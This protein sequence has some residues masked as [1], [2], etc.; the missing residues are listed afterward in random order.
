MEQSKKKLLFDYYDN[1]N[2]ITEIITQL[3][4]HYEVIVCKWANGSDNLRTK[5]L[6]WADIIFCEWGALNAIWYSMNKLPHQQ[7]YIRLHRWE[8]YSVFFQKIVWKNVT[9]TIFISPQIQRLAIL[10]NK[11][12]S[13]K[14]ICIYN[15]VKSVMF[16]DTDKTIDSPFNIGIM[17]ILPHYKRLDIAIDIIQYLNN[18]DNKYKLYILG[19]TY[20]DKNV[21]MSWKSKSERDFYESINKKIKLLHLENIVIFEPYTFQPEDWLKKIGFIL[22]LSDIEGSH[23]A[24][25][26]SMATGAIPCIYGKALH[27][28]KLDEIYPKKYCFYESNI[29]VLCDK[30]ISYSNNSDSLVNEMEYCKQFCR[31]NFTLDMIYKQI[32]DI[33]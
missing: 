5:Y 15:Y 20:K 16:S 28:F 3:Q 25:A 32:H 17:G 12:I 24:V 31:D 33:L 26:E 23:Q 6:K 14:S 10:Q 29:N 18:K 19:K 8:L 7:L 11:E 1:N 2:F 13:D 22:S 21:I 9:K 27:E 4:L 30:I